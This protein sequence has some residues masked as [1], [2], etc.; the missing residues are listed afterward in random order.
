MKNKRMSTV[1]TTVV[2]CISAACILLL[3]L[4]ASKNMTDAMKLSTENTMEM[5]L[6]AKTKAI[7]Q[8]VDQAEKLLIAY[9]KAP[10]VA[11]FLADPA[12]PELTSQAQAYTEDFYSSLNGWE[13]IYIA[14]WDSH[15]IAHSNSSVVGIYT[16]EGDPLNQLQDAMTAAGEIYNTGI[17]VSPA[18]QQLTLSLYAPVSD[19]SGKILGYAGGAQFASGLAE[20][21]DELSVP[22][23]ENASNYMINTASATH[24]FDEDESR[25]G[26][27]IEDQ[28]LLSVI[29]KIHADPSAQSGS[30]DYETAAGEKS[31]A[32]YRYLPDRQWAMILGD[33]EKEIYS[34][35]HQ[36]RTVFALV[37][38]SAFAAITALS[39]LSVKLCVRP[40]GIIEHAIERLEHLELET[41][42][43]IRQFAGKKSE[44]GRISTA[45]LSLYGTLQNIVSTLRGCTDSLGNSIAQTSDVSQTLIKYTEDNSAT[46]QQLSASITTTNNAIASVSGEIVRIS[47]MMD[48]VKEKIQAGDSESDQL[49]HTATAM[50]DLAELTLGET[51]TK[52]LENRKNVEE[53]ML[54]L[55]SLMRINDM[56]NQILEIANQTNL[57]SLNASIEAARAGDQGRGFAVVAQEIGTLAENSSSTAMQISEICGDISGNIKNVQDCVDDIIRF[58]EADV[59][60]KFQRFAEIANEYGGSVEDIRHAIGE[61]QETFHGFASSI[62]SI[63]E[64]ME[65]I[66]LA[67]DENETGV[68]DIVTKIEQTNAT[69]EELQKIGAATQQNSQEISAIV[70]KFTE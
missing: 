61:I 10:I 35:A 4:I 13:G 60:E 68:G 54:N 12:D 30:L 56:A 14:E 45:M 57:L 38:L 16:R 51:N 63:R 42:R 21:L 41:P 24:I 15:V 36:K 49:I 40:L 5:S 62:A 70:E 1:I 11:Q 64:H 66:R 32:M 17:I 8:Y 47:D 18:S 44:A 9:S 3:F 26:L 22:V 29:E 59:E 58:M 53:A 50:K 34:L 37:C 67:S 52:I 6:N 7:E 2:S 65:L 39:F 46:T 27:P 48:T 28:M 43:E 33:S 31:V 23:L 55:Q 20:I 69:A 19:A 25:M